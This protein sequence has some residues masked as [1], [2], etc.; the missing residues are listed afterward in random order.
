MLRGSTRSCGVKTGLAR[1]TCFSVNAQ[2]SAPDASTQHRARPEQT[3]GSGR[4][5]H[6]QMRADRSQHSPQAARQAAET[7]VLMLHCHESCGIGQ[8]S[9]AASLN[10][11]FLFYG[12]R[13]L[14]PLWWVICSMKHHLQSTWQSAGLECSKK[15]W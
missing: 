8:A 10:L 3:S 15:W 2:N 12:H 5:Q 14:L 1:P 4:G 9:L 6:L 13:I 7:T 11:R